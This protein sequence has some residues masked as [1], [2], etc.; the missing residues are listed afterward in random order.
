MSDERVDLIKYLYI[1]WIEH[2]E[3]VEKGK[4]NAMELLHIKKFVKALQ[5]Y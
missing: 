1:K 3:V 2:P 5:Y 4:T